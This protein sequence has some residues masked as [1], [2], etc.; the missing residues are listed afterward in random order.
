M[1]DQVSPGLD[2]QL[3]TKLNELSDAVDKSSKSEDSFLE[4]VGLGSAGLDRID[5]MNYAAL[6]ARKV[7]A[8]TEKGLTER[9]ERTFEDFIKRIGHLIDKS[10]PNLWNGNG[11][12]ASTSILLTLMGIDRMLDNALRWPEDQGLYAMP[13]K[14]AKRIRAAEVRLTEIESVAGNIDEKVQRIVAAHDA[15]DAFPADLDMLERAESRITEIRTSSEESLT[16]ITA[17]L[18]NAQETIKELQAQQHAAQVIIKKC[19]DAFRIATSVGLAG[20]FQQRADK[21]NFSLLIWSISL[22]AALSAGVYLG[23]ERL[24]KLSEIVSRSTGVDWGAIAMQLVLSV[25]S[26]G[27]PIWLAWL[28]TKQIGQRFRLAEDYAFKASVAKA[29]EGYRKEA[30]ELEDPSFAARLFGVALE[31]LEE[32]PLRLIAGENIHSTPLQELIASPAFR[33]AVES[34]TSLKDRLMAVLNAA[35]PKRATSS[36]DPDAIVISTT[37]K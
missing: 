8:A 37:P 12:P 30:A 21:L 14:L 36:S 24:A 27:A 31:R 32:A 4:T 23:G 9:Q 35:A 2:A 22:L 5:L 11:G 20:A 10:V 17:A 26:I 15:A 1:N 19:D 7:I 3:V 33:A 16:V 28:S 34:N 25:A 18:E 6:V 13:P 29:Y